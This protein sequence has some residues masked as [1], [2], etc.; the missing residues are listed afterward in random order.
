MIIDYLESI[1][2]ICTI[3][4][5]TFK[6]LRVIIPEITCQ[7]NVSKKCFRSRFFKLILVATLFKIANVRDI[8]S[9]NKYEKSENRYIDNIFIVYHFITFNLT[10]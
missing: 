5:E 9:F 6:V 1:L 4:G 7:K 10:F 2:R 8:S 3:Q